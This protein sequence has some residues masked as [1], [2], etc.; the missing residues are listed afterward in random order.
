MARFCLL[1][2]CAVMAA[3]SAQAERIALLVGNADYSS[4]VGELSN[5]HN[6]V[7]AI[8]A[9]LVQA[10]FAS[11]N[12]RTITD[13]SRIE[14][15]RETRL[16]AERAE[17][18]GADD[19]AF[20]YYSGHGARR[21]TGSG[22]SLIPTDVQ[23]V[24]NEDFW[25]ETVDLNDVI[26]TFVGPRGD[27]SAAA[28][29]VSIDACRNELRLPQRALGGGAKSFGVAPR[30]SGML[31]SFAA[32]EGQT[33]ADRSAGSATLSPYAKVLA[34]Q[35]ITPG[36]S[37]S[38]I[39]GAVRPGVRRLTGQAQQPVITNRLNSD[40][41]LIAAAT[42]PVER[43][44]VTILASDEGTAFAQAVTADTLA[45]YQAFRDQFPNSRHL[46]YVT[47]RITELTP[48]PV[49]ARPAPAPVRQRFTPGS[50]FRDDLSGGGRGPEMVV[51]PSGAFMMG[52]P[53]NE[54]GRDS[55]EGPQRRVTIGRNFAVGKYEVTVAEFDAFVRDTGYNAGTRCRTYE[56]G[57][58]DWRDGKSWGSP[59]FSQTTDHPVTCVDWDAAQAY[60]GWL[61]RKTGETYRL[62]TEAE[63]EYA[64]RAGTST[65]YWWG[66]SA[67]HEY[68]NYGADSC[69]SG[70]TSGRDQ[71]RNTSPAG[72]FPANAFGLHDMHG[73]VFEWVEDCYTSNYASQPSNG[74]A[75]T[76]QDCPIRVFRGGS[77]GSSPLYLRSAIRG[78]STPRLRSFI[79]GFRLARDLTD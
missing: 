37:L 38:T 30:T 45:A 41:V 7:A 67:S 57:S 11:H 53:A 16:F 58:W 12:I 43:E 24:D 46:S 14:L 1:V 6:D 25:Y 61:S 49:V 72:S 44:R 4:A 40:P 78:R 68:A 76:T 50:V 79:L 71:W 22:M 66:R 70:A 54:T 55:D 51:V 59:G 63:W 10:G 75:K 60:A 21:P 42:R 36:R 32:D 33:A 56:G 20:F 34:E 64:A 73:N 29:V 35:L 28:W 52:S 74:A 48:R 18:L 9:A 13:T 3:W 2:L 23:T 77:W 47:A 15:L 69:C 27:R 5:P 19:I 31:I 17:N 26:E 62:L 65:P 8:R 39:F